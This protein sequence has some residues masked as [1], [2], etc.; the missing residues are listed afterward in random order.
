[1]TSQTQEIDSFVIDPGLVL[2]Q[3]LALLDEQGNVLVMFLFFLKDGVVQRY[4]YAINEQSVQ[5]IPRGEDAAGWFREKAMDLRL[6]YFDDMVYDTSNWLRVDDNRPGY[7]H[8][9]R[10]CGEDLYYMFEDPDQTKE[11]INPRIKSVEGVLALAQMPNVIRIEEVPPELSK[12]TTDSPE[13]VAAVGDMS[14]KVVVWDM[15]E[16][17]RRA[18]S[19]TAA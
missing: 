18:R 12:L 10:L 16:I 17:Y 5:F 3:E 15:G 19:A 9:Y 2:D 7:N 6:E 4:V 14:E 1:M 8:C 13:W 11:S